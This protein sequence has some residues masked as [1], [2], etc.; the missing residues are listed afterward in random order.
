MRMWLCEG[1]IEVKIAHLPSPSQ[2]GACLS[3][4]LPKNL[5]ILCKSQPLSSCLDGLQSLKLPVVYPF[6]SHLHKTNI[7]IALLPGWECTPLQTNLTFSS[8]F[9]TCSGC[10]YKFAS[11][12]VS[13]KWKL[14]HPDGE[15]IISA[16]V[17]QQ[18][19]M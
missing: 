4:L 17:T 10:N 18:P 11:T 14:K 16:A 19:S 6:S 2:K 15:K 9:P 1:K 13:V 3:S 8:G 5:Y 7:N 12:Y